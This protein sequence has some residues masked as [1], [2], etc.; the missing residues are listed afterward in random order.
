[1]R[2]P[3]IIERARAFQGSALPEFILVMTSYDKFICVQQDTRNTRPAPAEETHTVDPPME[4][5]RPSGKEEEEVVVEEEASRE[6]IAEWPMTNGESKQEQ[7]GAAKGR[8][9]PRRRRPKEEVLLAG[10]DSLQ[11]HRPGELVDTL[12]ARLTLVLHASGQTGCTVALVTNL[13]A[14][15][16]GGGSGAADGTAG[17]AGAPLAIRVADGGCHQPLPDTRAAEVAAVDL[18]DAMEAAAKC[19]AG[20]AMTWRRKMTPLFF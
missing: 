20:A 6:L 15:A 1:M 14:R 5:T 7:S 19:H 2:F 9:Q 12:L 16:I 17:A 8:Q 10:I 4:A 13:G 11:H 3:T 18:A